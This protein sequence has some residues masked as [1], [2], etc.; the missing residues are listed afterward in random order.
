MRSHH[1][2]GAHRTPPLWLQIGRKDSAMGLQQN[3]Y[4]SLSETLG[5]GQ[6]LLNPSSNVQE[7]DKYLANC[8]SYDCLF[9]CLFI[10]PRQA[11]HLPCSLGWP[12]TGHPA[13]AS[14]VLC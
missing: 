13:L 5:Q 14:L 12:L 1:E 3:P 8:V 6:T 11:E 4:H 9:A 7:F 2:V 10:Q